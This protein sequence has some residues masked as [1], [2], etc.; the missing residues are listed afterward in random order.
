MNHEVTIGVHWTNKKDGTF[1]VLFSDGTWEAYRL[2]DGVN[3]IAIRAYL[4][5]RVCTQKKMSKKQVN[6]YI[7]N[8]MKELKRLA[9]ES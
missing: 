4:N 9:E 7:N 6:R 5:L 3:T 8:K 2:A 1:Y